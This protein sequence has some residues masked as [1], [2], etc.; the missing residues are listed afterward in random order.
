M[1][2]FTFLKDIEEY[3]AFGEPCINAESVFKE[4]PQS[5]I[6]ST[7]TALECAVKW[8]YRKD[9]RLSYDKQENNGSDLYY[10][11]TSST[12]KN[13][14]PGQLLSKIHKIR[15][16]AN[17]VLHDGYTA[18]EEDAIKCLEY[19]FYFVQWLDK[20]YGKNYE[21]RK[22]SVDKVPKNPSML[23]QGMKYAGAALGGVL[24]TVGAYLFAQD[25]KR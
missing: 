2:N 1:A 24:V 16:M 22:F 11:M 23:S 9:K 6:S 25:K 17:S 20:R 13:I 10:R 18:S 7:R 12:F 14:V 21:P 19:L 15:T 8:M 3:R 4:S 5:C